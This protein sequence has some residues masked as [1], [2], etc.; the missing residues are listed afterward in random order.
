M[1]KY[2][3]KTIELF[4]GDSQEKVGVVRDVFDDGI[5]V[6]ITRL[7]DVPFKSDLKIGDVMYYPTSKLIFKLK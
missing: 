7:G 6:V 5:E 3:G 2:I 4:P 1:K